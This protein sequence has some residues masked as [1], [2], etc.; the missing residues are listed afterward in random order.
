MLVSHNGIARGSNPRPFEASPFDSGYERQKSNGSP[1]A[2]AAS[3]ARPEA[4]N[5]FDMQPIR[6]TSIQTDKPT[7]KQT[8]NF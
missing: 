7:D 3:E 8:H 5:V 4:A 2:S 6:G 1:F